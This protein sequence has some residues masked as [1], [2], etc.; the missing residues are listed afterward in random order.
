MSWDNIEKSGFALGGWDYNEA[1]LAYSDDK[2][3]DTG[4]DVTYNSLGT[5]GTWTLLNKS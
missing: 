3:P 4:S 5:E 2:D 1:N